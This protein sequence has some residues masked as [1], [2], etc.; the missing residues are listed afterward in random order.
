MIKWLKLDKW[1]APTEVKRR[2][3]GYGVVIVI[4]F[5]T[6]ASAESCLEGLGKG[7]KVVERKEEGNG[8]VR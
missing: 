4:P 7:E 1:I 8:Y 5:A 2:G 3:N 6:K